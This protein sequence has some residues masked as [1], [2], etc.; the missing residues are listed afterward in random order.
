[1][2]PMRKMKVVAPSLPKRKMKPAQSIEEREDQL[3]ALAYDLAEQQLINGTASSQVITHFLKLGSSRE[4]LEKEILLKQKEQ[5][6]AKTDNL[7]SSAHSEE[8]YSKA[9]E[10]M[11]RY[12]GN[13]GDDE[14]YETYV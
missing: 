2:E 6:E 10:A 5:I 12:S 3:F 9:L 1:M 4:K 11:S 8:L 14:D 7:R 13:R